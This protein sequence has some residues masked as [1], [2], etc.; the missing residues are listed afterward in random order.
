MLVL[1]IGFIMKI[2]AMTLKKFSLILISFFGASLIVN[3]K[4]FKNH[5]QSI[6][7]NDSNIDENETQYSILF[8]S[9]NF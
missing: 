8:K 7:S 9:Y 5:I 6:W 4:W 3:P 1:V 2:E